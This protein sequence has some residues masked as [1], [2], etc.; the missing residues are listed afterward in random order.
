MS[1]GYTKTTLIECTRTQSDE[2]MANNN[3]NPATWT[4]RVGTGLH[5]KPGDQI[6]V[7]SSYISE[8]GA[9]SG[10]IQIKGQELGVNAS[11][12]YTEFT[13]GLF[14]DE[15]P[16]KYTLVNASNKTESI[17]L[18]D[19]T[20]NL[21]VSPYKCANGDNYIFLPRRYGASSTDSF[22]ESNER[23]DGKTVAAGND[24]GQT[25]KPPQP[26]NICKADIST[27]YWPYRVGKAHGDYK[28]TGKNDGSR[29]TLF[30]RTQTYYGAP[31]AISYTITGEAKAGS[32]IITLK[33]GGT[34]D[35]LL[36]GMELITQ[37]PDTVFPPSPVTS[38]LSVDSP[39]QI[40]LDANAS[41]NTNS[42]NLFTF[43]LPVSLVDEYL[44]PTTANST[45]NADECESFRDPA[46]WGDYIQ[47]KN[48]ISLK[49]N[50]GYN[51]PT[52]LAD[53]LTQEINERTDL[54]YFEY[55]T[56]N[57]SNT[58][59]RRETFSFKTESPAYKMYKCATATNF[60]KS[61]FDEWFKTDGSWNVN[62]AYHWLS[63]YQHIALKRPEIYTTGLEVNGSSISYLDGFSGRSNGLY[64]D[65]SLPSASGDPVFVTGLE[66]NR[67]NL[68]RF[69]NFFDTQKTYPELFDYTQNGIDCDIETT[70]FLHM[71]LYDNGN[72]SFTFASPFDV[73]EWYFGANLKNP[74]TPL[75]GYDLYNDSISASNTS[76]PIFIDYNPNTE[77]FTENDVGY[78]DRGFNYFKSDLETNYDDLAYGFARKIR[79]EENGL[80]ENRTVNYKIGFQFTRT[81]NK[82]P[83]HFFH[84]NASASAS[85]PTETLGQG[86]RIFGFDWHFTSYG[87][88]GML[89]WN[90]NV[91][92][93]GLNKASSS[94]FD[95]TFRFSQATGD[96]LYRLDP[97]Q[98]GLYL[99]ADTALIN[100]DQDQQRFQLSQLHQA[101]VVGQPD[102]AGF[103]QLSRIPTNP[104]A[105]DVCYK[106]NKRPL[107]TNYTPELTP[108]TDSFSAKYTGGS[109][110]T[111]I[112]HNVNIEPYRIMDANSGLFIE[113][114]IVPE[115]IWDETLVG[116][117]GF[118]Y[119]QFHNPDSTSSRQVR[120]KA[121]G[122]NADLHNVNI[123]TTNADVDEGDLISYFR[124]P[125]NAQMSLITNTVAT[126]PGGSGF[127][128]D[129][130]M[131]TPAI[132]VSPVSSVKITAK[133]LP[134]K[135]LRP[136]YSIRSDI[137]SDQPNGVL[138]GAT[139]GI[140][141]PTVAITN[142]ANPYGD[143]LNGFG[144]QLVFT[145]TN[146]RVLTRIR[147]S[148]HEADGSLARTDL[149][150]AIIFKI[151][152]Q[153]S[154]D[155]NLVD[156]L[157]QSKKKSDQ[158][159]A[160]NA[161]NPQEEF[162]NIQYKK[163]LFE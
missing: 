61:T 162:L 78:A 130:R 24:L 139:S 22:W 21:I 42:H 131:I 116:I 2:A 159:I 67:T 58:V 15:L 76:F 16:Q 3:Q 89:L 7:H 86:T 63:S 99:G 83:D 95:K 29:F 120:L 12:E 163:D 91:N 136:Y 155:L 19:D 133:R 62:S 134:T 132:T 97:Y 38:I 79:I 117:M 46:T 94:P 33:H 50:P 55:N 104:N 66:W 70:R 82:I 34:T 160:E 17:A 153:V 52:D 93:N 4:N 123:I 108:Y 75:F 8:I 59:H 111:Y 148:I 125:V 77:S 37:S 154:A 20:L 57:T 126:T 54:E 26:L 128:I 115:N 39:T 81:G 28:I 100:Y 142:K 107:G 161:L 85:D 74:K 80:G 103:N 158:E 118:R 92:I 124:N 122:A 84:T 11:V 40:T 96:R 112:S 137:V 119:E 121:H 141:L 9:E 45:Y 41:A 48:L 114:W 145:N 72:G 140:T 151:D 152:Q 36:E 87:C 157:L 1:N 110:N 10:Q 31:N 113:D 109:D 129:G 106:I 32:P 60:Q 69:K 156:T 88:L 90:G 101:E 53:Q 47:V 71:N 43:Q 135:T 5:L 13:E 14:N 44:P 56:S 149:N 147:C 146:D 30:T 27:K 138:G 35:N 143:F 73:K 150:S 144:S 23:R 127:T 49:A 51:S 68:L 64:S 6:S 25:H 102:I 65:F 98:F 18:R 105:G